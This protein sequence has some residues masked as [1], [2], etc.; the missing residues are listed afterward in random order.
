MTLQEKNRE[1]RAQLAKV[2]GEREAYWMA[3]DII[4]DVMSYSEV[5]I[6]VKG[7]DE[8][9]DFILSKIDAIVQRVKNGEP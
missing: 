8:L 3:R 4:E 7:N 2:V 5:D 9:S 6:I 1:I